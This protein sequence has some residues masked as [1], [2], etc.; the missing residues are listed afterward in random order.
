MGRSGPIITA[1]IALTVLGASNAYAY[2]PFDS[3]DAD[4]AACR[5]IELEIGPFGYLSTV[6]GR[7]LVAPALIVNYGLSDRVELVAEGK[8]V[9]PLRRTTGSGALEDAALSLKVLLRR[10]S[11][12]E[13]VG[14]SVAVEVAALLP[15]RGQPGT[16]TSITGIV[17][18]QWSS[19]TLHVNAE[20]FLEPSGEVGGFGST[21]L[22]GPHRWRMRP[23][24]E[25]GI[26]QGTTNVVSGLGG[27]IWEL[28]DHLS[29][30]AGYRLAR[31]DGAFTHEFRAGFTWGLQTGRGQPPASSERR[32]R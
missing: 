15:V 19:A 8:H 14:P 31:E 4:V 29:V 25:F 13:R 12:Q 27:A 30:D 10:G 21:I 9:R 28:Q 20:L 18:Q 26:E 7:F 32:T 3:T 11:L 6:E 22:E 23:V 5:E 2:R 17:S 16:G 24:G 1:L